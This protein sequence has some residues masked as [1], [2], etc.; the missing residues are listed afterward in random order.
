MCVTHTYALDTYYGLLQSN[1]KTEGDTLGVVVMADFV[2][3]Q[4][5][6]FHET[7]EVLCANRPDFESNFKVDWQHIDR[8]ADKEKIRANLGTEQL[9]SVIKNGSLN[10]AECKRI[11]GSR[12]E[13]AVEGHFKNFPWFDVDTNMENVVAVLYVRVIV[14]ERLRRA[15]HIVVTAYNLWTSKVNPCVNEVSYEIW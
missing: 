9:A 14:R 13:I 2:N 1:E 7:L 3:K 15:P 5:T 11:K 12:C 8:K 4:H 6:L 10:L